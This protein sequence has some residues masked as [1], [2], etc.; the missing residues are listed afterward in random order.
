MNLSNAKE[1]AES[2]LIVHKLFDWHFK[3][4]GAKRRYGQ[5]LYRT[6]TITLSR[7][8]T[9]LNTEKHVKE[10]IIHEIAHALTPYQHHNRI[11]QL[12]AIELGIRP[13]RCAIDKAKV[14]PNFKAICFNCQHVHTRFRRTKNKREA[15]AICC[16]KFN[17]GKF[18]ERFVL[19]WVDARV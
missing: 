8:L 18:T 7:H 3:F 5:C 6:K 17:N 15:C 9:L 10:T 4:D 14:E 12:K 19:K 13:N 11:W 1:L 16:R 2:L